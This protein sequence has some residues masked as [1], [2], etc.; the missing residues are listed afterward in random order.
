MTGM[1]GYDDSLINTGAINGTQIDFLM[2]EGFLN[3]GSIG[4]FAGTST[5]EQRNDAD[6]FNF[7]FNTTTESSVS[8]GSI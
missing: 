4:T 2:I 5:A 3:G 8:I 6:P 7:N 1:F